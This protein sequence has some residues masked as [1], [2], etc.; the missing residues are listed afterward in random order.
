[1]YSAK[2]KQENAHPEAALLVAGDFNAGK[3]KSVVPNFYQH[4]KCAASGKKL[5]TTFTQHTETHTKLFLAVHFE[6]LTIILD[7]NMFRDSS[8][9]IEEYTTSVTDFINKCID[10]VFPHSDPTYIP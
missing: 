1:L 10:D 4:F 2:S 5:W 8:D 9:G 6:N 3:L 7:W